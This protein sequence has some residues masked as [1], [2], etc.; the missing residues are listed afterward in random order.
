VDFR[1]RANTKYSNVVGLGSHDKGRA[2]TGGM[3]IGKKPKN[4]KVFDVLIADELI[5]KIYSDRG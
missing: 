3:G 5:Q 2:H 1:S 4:V